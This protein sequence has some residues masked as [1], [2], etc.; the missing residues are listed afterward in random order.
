[1]LFRKTFRTIRLY[2]AQFISMIVMTA[3]GIG[4][5]VGFNMEWYSIERNTNKFFDETGF[6]DYR[7]LMKLVLVVMTLKKSKI[8]MV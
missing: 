5:F 4:V 7:V 6:A 8:L 3:I 2:L 1:M